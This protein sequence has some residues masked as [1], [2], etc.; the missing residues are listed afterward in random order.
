[1]TLIRRTIEAHGGT[2]DMQWRSDGPDITVSL[3][4]F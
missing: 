1:L 4:G 3:P 2:L